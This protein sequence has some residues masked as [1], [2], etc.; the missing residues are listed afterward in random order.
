MSPSTE[1]PQKVGAAPPGTSCWICLD[2]GPGD[3]GEDDVLMRGCACRGDSGWVHTSCLAGYL[4]SKSKTLYNKAD[5]EEIMDSRA[6]KF[7]RVWYM[8]PQCNQEFKKEQFLALAETRFKEVV[9]DSDVAKDDRR[10]LSAMFF[11][12][13][14][15]LNNTRECSNGA[16]ATESLLPIWTILD[17]FLR[18]ISE[19][20]SDG[21]SSVY[22]ELSGLYLLA[23]VLKR[24]TEGE[25][26]KSD[27]VVAR[28]RELLQQCK[29]LV[30]K[31]PDSS[32]VTDQCDEIKIVIGRVIGGEVNLAEATANWRKRLK[33]IEEAYGPDHERSIAS[34]V[35]LADRLFEEGKVIEAIAHMKKTLAHSKRVLGPYHPYVGQQEEKL[36]I[37]QVVLLQ[38]QGV[39]PGIGHASLIS[40][41]PNLNGKPVFIVRRAKGDEDKFVVKMGETK[42][43]VLASKLLFSCGTPVTIKDLVT[44]SHL[45]GEK[46]E[47][48]SFDKKKG[49]YVL[50]RKDGTKVLVKPGNIIAHG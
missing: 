34:Q 2:D 35:V 31:Y 29:D 9:G 21:L 32:A 43:K 46:A 42:V 14:G 13:E 48:E 36:A 33:R 23:A 16:E 45:N 39:D 6:P 7:E 40:D 49:R 26:G 41:N 20:R 47:V 4:S 15:M 24:M 28:G 37:F 10:R 38:R 8:C 1:G 25:E 19:S 5:Q 27:R 12:A 30:D 22:F 50:I 3:A 44:A 17:E 18:I 11:K